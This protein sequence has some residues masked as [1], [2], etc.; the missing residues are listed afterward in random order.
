MEWSG[1]G[2][3]VLWGCFADGSV[4]PG[5]ACRLSLRS[6][7]CPSTESVRMASWKVRRERRSESLGVCWAGGASSDE[8]WHVAG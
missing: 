8:T 3:K 7:V 2:V 6:G 4:S 1:L 5:S